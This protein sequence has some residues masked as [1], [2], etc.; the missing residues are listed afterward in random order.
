[1]GF[2]RKV[3]SLLR[4]ET[5]KKI[6]SL[7]ELDNWLEREQKVL[8]GEIK[9]LQEEFLKKIKEKEELLRVILN[10]LREELEVLSAKQATSRI[11]KTR[12]LLAFLSRMGI[13]SLEQLFPK[14]GELEKTL[15][16]VS[17]EFLSFQRENDQ[18][19]ENKIPSKEFEALSSLILEIKKEND[20]F[21]EQLRGKK[22]APYLQLVDLSRKMQEKLLRID[23]LQGAKEFQEQRLKKVRNQKEEKNNALLRLKD[24]PEYR[25]LLHL[26]EEEKKLRKELEE[27]EDEI[28]VFLSRV[29][30]SIH[31]LSDLNPSFSFSD[32]LRVIDTSQEKVE[33]LRGENLNLLLD[34]LG[35]VDKN[36]IA[37]NILEN[38]SSGTF[39]SLFK[40]LN[41]ANNGLFMNLLSQRENIKGKLEL[42]PLEKEKNRASEQQE[43]LHYR[44]AHFQEGEKQTKDQ[45]KQLFE[46]LSKEKEQLEQKRQQFQE[47]CERDFSQAVQVSFFS[48]QVQDSLENVGVEEITTLETKNP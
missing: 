16:D 24:S 27:T 20:S 18:R 4:S 42:L 34:S 13:T 19:E 28:F 15:G 46:S 14:L 36:I 45:L 32:A 33:N 31:E 41:R 10:Q 23:E 35:R 37:G 6:L 22:L 9:P 8:Q 1:M 39:S 12:A 2:L 11:E 29:K 38:N 30:S 44:L 7:P 3:N 47:I 5:E 40:E 43:D 48:N 25:S 26:G 21:L 17:V